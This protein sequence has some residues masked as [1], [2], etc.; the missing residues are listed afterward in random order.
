MDALRFV[1][2]FDVPFHKVA[3]AMLGHL[4]FLRA[5]ASQRRKTFISTGMST[6]EEL[7]QVVELFAQSNCPIE[8][9]HCNSTYPMR[10][11]D[12][13]LGCIPMLRARYGVD[14]GYSGHETSLV[15]VCVSAVV[16]GATSIERHITLD[17][18]MYGSDQAA[19]V[20]VHALRGF[21]DTIRRIPHIVG[22]GIKTISPAEQAV[23]QKL[24]VEVP[25]VEGVA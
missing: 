24:R 9:L 25:D 19:S 11:E 20:E 2:Q 5:V 23:R 10:E 16:L 7:D 4:P 12:A 14:V 3:S 21:V 22:D 8:L 17:R 6:L 13:N 1:S 18:A 15:K